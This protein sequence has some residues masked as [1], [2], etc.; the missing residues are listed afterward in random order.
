MKYF[1]LILFVVSGVAQA[2]TAVEKFSFGRFGV[3][4][5]YRPQAVRH[6]VLLFSDVS[7]WSANDD[8]SARA[9]ADQDILVA[10]IDLHHYA[11]ELAKPRDKCS[12]LAGEFEDYSHELQKQFSRARYHLPVLV[13][14][15]QAAGLLYGV[16]AQGSSGTFL[17]LVTIGF[18]PTW[19]PLIRLCQS[20]GLRYEA[21]K[22]KD[23]I[24]KPTEQLSTPWIAISFGNDQ[25]HDT[26]E[27]FVEA[28]GTAKLKTAEHAGQL[29]DEVL[30]SVNVLAEPDQD[31]K[32]FADE[33]RDLPLEEVR[34]TG[35][36]GRKLA[37]F[38]T[39]DGGWAEID[40]GVSA[41]LVT[42]GIDV[43]A[44]NSL[45]YFWR[46]RSPEETA[47]DVERVMRHYVAAWNK[48]E[49][50]VIGYSFGADVASFVVNRLSPDLLRKVRSVSLLGAA[51]TADFEV[52]VTTWLGV[53]HHGLPAQPEVMR[54]KPSVLCVY[55]EGESD[56][57][58]PKLA[59]TRVNLAK[60]G[61]GHHFG[62]RY[63]EL[64]EKIVAVADR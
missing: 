60:I 28:V 18:T 39:G 48:A 22:A 52:H 29:L 2:A 36:A 49:V 8:K 15:G 40:K 63:A 55:G 59:G 21:A 56:S 19:K 25:K 35:V 41:Q 6:V 58:C 11:A 10:G 3:T 62:D 61:T 27:R 38:L 45:Q 53:D 34:A 42:K 47:K 5:V 50:L 64:A 24:L 57:L 17:G 16:T 26:V 23:V 31:P 51:E 1:V 4:S 13:G 54:L 9:L 12:Y 32:V 7:G 30:Q 46:P 37:V 33:L 14:A 20:Y 43:V 44:L